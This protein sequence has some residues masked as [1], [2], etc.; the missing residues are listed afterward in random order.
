MKKILGSKFL[1]SSVLA[2]SMFFSAGAAELGSLIPIGHT[3][4]IQM[5]SDG[6]M[7]VRLSEVTTANGSVSPARDAG[8]A[9]GDIILSVNGQEV[10]SND[11]LQKQIALSA[12]GAVQ[13]EVLQSS[14]QKTVTVTPCVDE[15]G[16][17]RVGIL[18]RD[19][20]AGIGTITYVDPN[21]G[22]YGALGHGICET[23][24]GVLIPV[25]EGELVYSIVS[26]VKEGTSGDPGALQGEFY[27][28]ETVGTV[29]RNTDSG[30]F[31][32]ITDSS[33]YE[34][35]QVYPVAS[36]DE[37]EVGPAEILSNVSGDSTESY[38]IE[39]TQLFP[40]DDEYGRTMMITITDEA[41]IKQT[42]GIV[43]GMSGSPI[44][45]DGKLI[46]A[47][48][49]VLVNDPQSGYGISVEKMLETMEN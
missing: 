17:S 19:S 36:E 5:E 13:M 25:R 16:V 26:S 42:G 34:G 10:T 21:T 8:L 14:G 27:M 7:I 15:N 40:A 29:D 4:G 39:V 37:I 9:A 31:G 38:A 43:Q 24:T 45:Q 49:H 46:G 28:N 20:M 12:G 35:M 6:I 3:V 22:E 30:I 47:V 33:F 44:I 11:D 23:E 32:E 41:L 18:A 1:L 2:F 48:T